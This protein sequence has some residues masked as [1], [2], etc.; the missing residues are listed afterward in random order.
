MS[1]SPGSGLS[2]YFFAGDFHEAYRRH[3][4]GEEQDYATHVEIG[5][6][7]DQLT[8]VGTKVRIHS[9]ISNRRDVI[10]W[11]SKLEFVSLGAT[12]RRSCA[13]PSRKT[14]LQQSSLTSQIT[15]S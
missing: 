3:Q 6:L 2:I 7:V 15:V 12:I 11:S 10:R 1:G 13:E 8:E 5:K 4:E 9:F 14:R